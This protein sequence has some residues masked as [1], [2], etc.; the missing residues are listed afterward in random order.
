[1]PAHPMSVE[2]RETVPFTTMLQKGAFLT[3]DPN[4]WTESRARLLMRAASYPQVERIF[5]NPAIK[6][7]MCD[8]WRGDRTN[9]AKLRP[10]YGH[11]SHFHIRIKCPPGAASCKPP[12]PVLLTTDAANR[13]HGGSR[14]N[15]G[16]RRAAEARYEAGQAARSDG[17]RSSECLLVGSHGA[18]RQLGADG[19]LWRRRGCCP[20]GRADGAGACRGV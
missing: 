19:H 12:A 18:V 5:V 16:R 1:M 15:H 2:A 3:I 11:D 14:R 4:V 8:T 7:K 20:E 17:L 9:L 6:K 10:I 13:W